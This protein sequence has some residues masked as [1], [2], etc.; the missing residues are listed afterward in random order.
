MYPATSVFLKKTRSSRFFVQ[1]R[2]P[3]GRAP[4]PI[5]LIRDSTSFF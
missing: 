4:H 5:F 3:Y 1:L 2:V